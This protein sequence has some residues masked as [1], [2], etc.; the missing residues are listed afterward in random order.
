MNFYISNLIRLNLRMKKYFYTHIVLL[1]FVSSSWAQ[2][3]YPCKAHTESGEP[4]D[5]QLEWKISPKGEYINIVFSN[6]G[7]EFEEEFLYVLIDKKSGDSYVPHDSKAYHIDPSSTWMVHKY[8]LTEPGE[9]LIYFVNSTQK[10]LAEQKIKVVYQDT[11][12]YS[13]NDATN[14]YYDNCQ[15]LMCQRVIG[16][17]P[18]QVL[19]DIYLKNGSATVYVYINNFKSFNTR[20][21][22]INVWRK[23]ITGFEF[24]EYV[25]QR[26]FR[27]DPTWNDTFFKYSFTEPGEYK[28]AVYNEK[29]ILIKFNFIRVHQR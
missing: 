6:D 26:N 18:Y 12:S 4:I 13:S 25:N 10:R 17:K 29:D 5:Y 20:K 24:D 2:T 27:I 28:I 14:V 1:I 3:I 23:E 16:G 8:K 21:L 7:K 9:Y 19:S 22:T 11:H 15:M